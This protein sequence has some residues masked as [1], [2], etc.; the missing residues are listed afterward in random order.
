MNCTILNATNRKIVIKGEHATAPPQ[1]LS[2]SSALDI[3][4]EC[5]LPNSGLLTDNITFTIV[6]TKTD[7]ALKKVLKTQWKCDGNLDV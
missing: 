5:A 1:E 6:E 4:V 3:V 7:L 2:L